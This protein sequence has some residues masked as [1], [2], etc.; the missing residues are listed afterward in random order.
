MVLYESNIYNSKAINHLIHH[1][2]LLM[3]VPISQLCAKQ[4]AIAYILLSIEGYANNSQITTYVSI[5]IMFHIT[6]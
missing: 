6:G 1:Y 5:P 2:V 3:D 4:L